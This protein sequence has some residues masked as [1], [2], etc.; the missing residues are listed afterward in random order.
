MFK[1]VK[2]STG[3]CRIDFMSGFETEDEAYEM[4]ERLD[5][6]FLDENGFDW[7]L[8]VEEVI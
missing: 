3:G 2:K 5:Y 6:H 1:I 4:V 7:D 8:Y